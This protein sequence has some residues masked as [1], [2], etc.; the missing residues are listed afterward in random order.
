MNKRIINTFLGF[1]AGTVTGAAIGILMAPD[2]GTKT[3]KKISKT[4]KKTSKE[5]NDSINDQIDR[6][7]E[8]VN[9]VTG[10][11]KKKSDKTAKKVKH[12]TTD[13]LKKTGA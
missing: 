12:M 9:L 10:Q 1:A 5:V 4:V 2:K 3:R 8:K 6:L 7:S 11:L 13:M